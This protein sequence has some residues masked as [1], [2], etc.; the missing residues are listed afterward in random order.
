MRLTAGS[1]APCTD[2]SP[3]PGNVVWRNFALPALP[4]SRRERASR[5]SHFASRVLAPTFA[6][7]IGAPFPQPCL[8]AAPG[9]TRG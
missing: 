2:G 5:A 6:A 9:R 1:S 3:T 4:P 8:I 7:R